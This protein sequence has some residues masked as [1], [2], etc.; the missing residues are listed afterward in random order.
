MSAMKPQRS[1]EETPKEILRRY[2]GYDH[3]RPMQEEVINSLLEGH[4]TLALMP[5]G[6]G[7]SITYQVPAMMCEGVALVISPL[8]ALMKDQV[9]GLR[10]YDI[11]AGYLHHGQSRSEMLAVLD[12]CTFGYYKLLYVSPERL[13]N[14]LFLRRI[15]SIDI[16][17]VAVDEAHCI[18]QWGY[19]FRPHYTRIKEFRQRYP[20]L[21]FMALTA[22]ATPKV[23][24]DIQQ[25]LLFREGHQLFKKSFHRK[26]LTYV[27]RET[28]DKP[29]ELIHI[30]SKVEGSA[31]IYVR[32]RKKCRTISNMLC[33]N[34][35][36][37]DYFHALLSPELK[38]KK[39]NAWQSGETRIMV[40]TNAFGMGI[41][42]EDVRLVIH[43][44]APPSPEFYY[45]EA[46]RAGRDN[47]RAYAVL[48]Y[49][50]LEDENYLDMMLDR[51][52][53]PEATV[54]RLYD[55]LGSYFQLGVESGEG[56]RYEFDIYDF[57]VRYNVASY[58]V[59]AS[60]KILQLSGYMEY[61]ENDELPSMVMIIVDRQ[62]LYTLFDRRE[63]IYD[64]VIE[65]M[66]R[67]YPG[68]F[69]QYVSID[70]RYLSRLLGIRMEVLIAVLTNMRKWHVIDYIPHKRGNYIYYLSQRIPS[71]ELK[72]PK[73]I[74]ESRYEVAKERVEAM[75]NYMSND[76]GC[77][78]MQ[79]VTYF[80]E[81]N[82]LPCGY[83]DYCLA[84]PPKGLSYKAIDEIEA[85]LKSHKEIKIDSLQTQF[86]VLTPEEI[87]SAIE[88]LQQEYHTIKVSSDGWLTY[89]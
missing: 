8:V 12:N 86:S 31:L 5:T 18:S 60:L 45:Q 89:L 78:A 75:Q 30:L 85:Y 38:A 51:E 62:E 2:W 63:E 57:C 36:S 61:V 15:E 53:P 83:C 34:G 72:I 52:F 16:S 21:T 79:L 9:D 87:K 6:G 76:R 10:R 74:Y 50:P 84:H 26:E 23:V 58:M 40:C 54:R 77:R 17:F 47:K 80:A 65:C 37:S 35:F 42:K 68:L 43:P 69:S 22:T 66:M 4:D 3:F 27:V 71:K 56:A 70:E 46:G 48:L 81:S 41:N 88:H 82:P 19:D 64:D 32:S 24:E 59:T 67:Q 7:K 14:Q 73:A 29:R 28:Y 33:E 25:Q 20:E 11:N 55:T 13:T 39:Q 44:S 49:E 1:G